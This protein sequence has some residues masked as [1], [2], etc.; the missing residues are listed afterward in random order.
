MWDWMRVI[1]LIGRRNKGLL[2]INWSGWILE[3]G[4]WIILL[5]L[6]QKF[7]L[8]D[9]GKEFEEIEID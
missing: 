3:L 6:H 7:F 9:L 4:Q 2:P 8:F 1:W 5:K